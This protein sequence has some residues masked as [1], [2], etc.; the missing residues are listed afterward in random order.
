[1]QYTPPCIPPRFATRNINIVYCSVLL[2]LLAF[3]AVSLFLVDPLVSFID[4]TSKPYHTSR[5]LQQYN[6][7]VELFIRLYRD[8]ECD[9][10]HV[11][12]I[13]Y[14]GITFIRTL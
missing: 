11:G 5:A 9:S 3:P 13:R 7:T 4:P 8:F 10:G 12:R 2:N 6:S 1:M 14:Y